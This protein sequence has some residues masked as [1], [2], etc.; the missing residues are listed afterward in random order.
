MQQIKHLL[1]AYKIINRKMSKNMQNY[2]Y[3]KMQLKHNYNQ[4]KRQ[5]KNLN[6]KCNILKIRFRSYRNQN[7][8]NNNHNNYNNHNNRNNYNNHNNINNINRFHKSGKMIISM[9]NI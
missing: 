9:M 6:K 1:E 4:K 5:S 3:K 7:N 2:K 8:F